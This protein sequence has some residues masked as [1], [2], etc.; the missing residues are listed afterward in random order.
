MKRVE[1]RRGKERRV[2]VENRNIERLSEVTL[3]CAE[4]SEKGA[5]QSEVNGLR[6]K[7][8]FHSLVEY[9]HSLRVVKRIVGNN[10]EE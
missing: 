1:T 8:Y 10:I 5:K 4:R 6:E 7:T 3:R 9:R 2:L